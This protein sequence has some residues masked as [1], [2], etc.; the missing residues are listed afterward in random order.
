MSHTASS[1]TT[2][3]NI[4]NKY[5]N[6]FFITPDILQEIIGKLS[7]NPLPEEY[8]F[9]S[10]QELMAHLNTK[11]GGKNIRKT[12]KRRKRG[13][14]GHNQLVNHLSTLCAGVIDIQFLEPLVGLLLTNTGAASSI[15]VIHTNSKA[16]TSIKAFIVG[17]RH[18]GVVKLEC[19]C[20]QQG[21]SHKI[22]RILCA[23]FIGC[24]LSN[25]NKEIK[26][27][28]DGI[29]DTRTYNP[30]NKRG[31]FTI[32]DDRKNQ[33][34][35]KITLDAVGNPNSIK[36]FLEI[37]FRPIENN[38]LD[39]IPM[40]LY[41]NKQVRLFNNETNKYHESGTNEFSVDI[42][43]HSIQN[44]Y[45]IVYTDEADVYSSL[46]PLFESEIQAYTIQN[47]FL[48]ALIGNRIETQVKRLITYYNPHLYDSKSKTKPKQTTIKQ[49]LSEHKEARQNYTLSRRH[50]I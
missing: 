38:N 29:N 25:F 15:F 14:N 23:M 34:M 32:S 2:I 50:K 28:V 39:I 46:I 3:T 4:F 41:T 11:R 6:N 5:D 7:P 30:D 8:S 48:K 12:R 10:G 26:Q 1:E 13:G 31:Q 47:V 9:I 49:S 36:M 35:P 20:A 45:P 16:I 17:T 18:N 37:G 21:F 43:L 44:K 42:L 22:G 27:H 40:E 33:L 24:I 19:V